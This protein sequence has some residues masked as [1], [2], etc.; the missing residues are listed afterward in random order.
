MS[1]E[2]M[3]DESRSARKQLSQQGEDSVRESIEAGLRDSQE[4]RTVPLEEARRRFRLDGVWVFNSGG[5]FPAAVFSTRERAEAWIAERRVSGVLTKY[6]L[7]TAVY[8][9]AIACGAFKPSRPDHSE[10]RF[11][12][13]FSSASQEHYHFRDGVAASS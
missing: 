4:G 10:P 9:W 2:P 12:A 11:I 3:N 6:T 13:R 1:N 7:D 8:D 5:D